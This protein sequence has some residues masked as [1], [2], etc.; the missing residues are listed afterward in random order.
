M[1][2]DYGP[3]RWDILVFWEFLNVKYEDQ[4][5]SLATNEWINE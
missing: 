1:T 5:R 3:V 4:L 2:H